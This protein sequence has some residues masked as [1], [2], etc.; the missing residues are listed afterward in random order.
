MIRRKEEN[1]MD[2]LVQIYIDKLTNS[3][4]QYALSIVEIA[5]LNKENEEL[6]KELNKVNE[7]NKSIDE[8]EKEG[9]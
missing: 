2:P 8:N 9:D 5:R 7:I 1:S 4:Y 3:E 6:K